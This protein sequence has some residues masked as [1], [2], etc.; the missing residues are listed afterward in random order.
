[1]RSIGTSGPG[2]AGLAG[3]FPVNP[4]HPCRW[5]VRVADDEVVRVAPRRRDNPLI[6]TWTAVLTRKTVAYMSSM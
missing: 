6:R 4:C 2:E 3:H 1:V 5:I